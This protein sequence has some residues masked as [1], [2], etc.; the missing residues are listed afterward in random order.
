MIIFSIILSLLLITNVL[1]FI[2]HVNNSSEKENLPIIKSDN[3]DNK[4][5]QSVSE[6]LYKIPE[7]SKAV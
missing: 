2:V 5:K 7:Y 6:P 3:L 1:L 4:D